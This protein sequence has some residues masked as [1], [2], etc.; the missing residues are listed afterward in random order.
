MWPSGTR[1]VRCKANPI[2]CGCTST[3]VTCKWREK[4]NSRAYVGRISSHPRQTESRLG[5]DAL[6]DPVRRRDCPVSLRGASAPPSE[7]GRSRDPD[8]FA[9]GPRHV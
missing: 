4:E 1:M 3:Q 2:E 7:P 8:P 6:L 9:D 5:D